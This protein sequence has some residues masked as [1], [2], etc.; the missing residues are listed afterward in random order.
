ME[1]D[2]LEMFSN[3][4]FSCVSI[5]NF[6]IKDVPFHKTKVDYGS[7]NWT[8]HD[9]PEPKIDRHI[10]LT[11]E[12]LHLNPQFK[13]I[14]PTGA[15]LPKDFLNKFDLIVVSHFQNYLH[16]IVN[17]INLDKTK[18]VLCTV[19]QTDPSYERNLNI[20][21]DKILI[22]RFAKTEEGVQGYCGADSFIHGS[23]SSD[24]N[25]QWTGEIPQ[26]ITVA[27]AVTQRPNHVNYPTML[28]VMEGLPSKIYGS[29][30]ETVPIPLSGG[31]LDYLSLIN[32]YKTNRAFLATGV[33]PGPINYT[34]IEAMFLGIPIVALGKNLARRLTG[35]ANLYDID[36]YIE[37]GVNGF[38]SD[39][40]EDLKEYSKLLLN[41]LSLA[42][43]IS[44]ESIKKSRVLFS[45]ET[46]QQKWQTLFKEKGII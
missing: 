17:N 44:Q 10:D 46:I 12:F 33:C 13:G 21:R 39:K 26:L 9:W 19:G 25:V 18:V 6:T 24:F 14:S 40:V 1:A 34:F 42:Q 3:L 4:G 31:E 32:T 20:I 7:M 29:G 8:K 11:N 28:Q 15:N 36:S 41:D 22:N 27:R 5:G 35:T 38:V 2:E 23:V 30:N 43:S 16:H 37:N 45:R